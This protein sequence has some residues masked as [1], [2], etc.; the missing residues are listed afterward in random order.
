MDKKNK[1]NFASIPRDTYKR[2]NG[3]ENKDEAFIKY[4][5]NNLYPNYLIDL[6]NHSTIH[7]SCVNAIVEAVR[8]EGLVTE[9]ESVLDYANKTGESWNDI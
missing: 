7:A 5:E 3:R 2:V 6:Y 9:D 1:I 4:G 8:G